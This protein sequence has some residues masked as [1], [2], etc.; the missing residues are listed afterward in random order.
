LR[1]KLS[2]IEG[3]NAQLLAVDLQEV[4][5]AKFLLKD[6]GLSTDDLQYPLLM[7]PSLTVSAT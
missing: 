2:T 7:V 4:W 3:L 1:K 6:T 5:S